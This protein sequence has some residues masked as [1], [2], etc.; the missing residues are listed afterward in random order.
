MP[1][2]AWMLLIVVT[3]IS[4]GMI[5]FTLKSKIVTSPEGIEYTS[6]GIQ[7]KATWNQIEKIEFTPDGFVKLYFKEPIYT[8]SFVNALYDKTILLSPY[9]GDLSTSNLL[10]ELANYVP[11]SNIP[12][13]VAQQ[14]Y[15]VKTYQEAG[16]IGLYYLG[17]FIVWFLFAIGFQ[18]RVEEYL[19]TLG[20]SDI[21]PMLTFVG[22]S[23][24]IG[25]F[26]NSMILLRRYNAEIVKL[27]ENEISHKARTYYLSPLVI[28]LI[29]VLVSIG[30]RAFLQTRPNNEFNIPSYIPFLI[31]VVALWVS[32]RIERLLFRDD[33]E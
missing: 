22:L 4:I 15:S 12:E 24:V 8:N 11:D 10:K 7:A 21:D 23:L 29:S 32:T 17:W 2:G 16:V 5:Y 14:K 27:N 20:L 25:L 1:F 33:L 6:F 31:G 30:T 26:I 18:K 13:F 9:T 19:A 3:S 28:I